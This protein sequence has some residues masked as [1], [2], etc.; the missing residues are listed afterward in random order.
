MDT[1]SLT[2]GNEASS[3]LQ[4]FERLLGNDVFF[5]PCQFGTKRPLLTYVD[6]PFEVTKTAAYKSVFT[7]DRTN[8]AV[9]LGKASGGLCAIDLTLMRT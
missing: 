4:R 8:I 2:E 6:R 9:Y 7:L 1:E 3:A 5:V